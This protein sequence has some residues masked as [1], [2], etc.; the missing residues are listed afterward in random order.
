MIRLPYG[1]YH[2]ISTRSYGQ[3]ADLQLRPSLQ[4]RIVA[5]MIKLLVP[6]AW[7]TSAPVFGQGSAREPHMT[8]VIMQSVISQDCCTRCLYLAKQGQGHRAESDLLEQL[9]DHMHCLSASIATKCIKTSD[10]T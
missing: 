5:Y 3:R 2:L 4:W 8:A 7:S 6:T 1:A 9:P 10:P